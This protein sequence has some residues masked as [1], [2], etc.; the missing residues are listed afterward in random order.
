[1]MLDLPRY[2]PNL[3]LIERLGNSVKAEGLHGRPDRAPPRWGGR[4]NLSVRVY[5]ALFVV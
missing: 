5:G 4:A 1:M 2:S 3:N